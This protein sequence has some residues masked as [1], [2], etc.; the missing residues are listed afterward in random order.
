MPH[1]AVATGIGVMTPDPAGKEPTL[2][3]RT[4]APR[5]RS[6]SVAV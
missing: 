1:A 4:P 5:S 3:S 2:T 6:S